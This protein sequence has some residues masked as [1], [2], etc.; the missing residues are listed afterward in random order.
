MTKQGLSLHCVL[1][2]STHIHIIIYCT[3]LSDTMGQGQG[4]FQNP[5]GLETVLRWKKCYISLTLYRNVICKHTCYECYEC[6][7]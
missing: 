5:G 4:P 3:A 7:Q 2:W 6:H 1:E